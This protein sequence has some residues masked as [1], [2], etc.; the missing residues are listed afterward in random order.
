MSEARLSHVATLLI[1]CGIAYLV[2]KNRD[3]VIALLLLDIAIYLRY[4]VELLG[5]GK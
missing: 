4:V 5:G 2:T 3:I 1:V